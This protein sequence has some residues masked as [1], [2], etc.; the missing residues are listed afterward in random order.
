MASPAVR[1]TTPHRAADTMSNTSLCVPSFS[2]PHETSATHWNYSA[3]CGMGITPG[4]R[5]LPA[6]R[7]ATRPHADAAMVSDE[8]DVV[9]TRSLVKTRR[10]SAI[11][12]APMAALVILADAQKNAAQVGV[13]TA[14]SL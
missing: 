6:R 14:A 12:V 2:L 9:P 7:E 5:K 4:A 10:S 11:C 3:Y 8:F 1:T 13:P